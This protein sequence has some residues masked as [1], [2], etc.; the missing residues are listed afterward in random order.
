MPH[1]PRP[2]CD[3]AKAPLWLA[4][5]VGTA[6]LSLTSVAP[7]LAADA[8]PG[9]EHEKTPASQ[10]AQ[11]P[12]LP[13]LVLPKSYVDE[14]APGKSFTLVPAKDGSD[15]L[16][17]ETPAFTARVSPNG[18][19]RFEDHAPKLS[20]RPPLPE[21]VRPGTPTIESALRGRLKILPATP[22]RPFENRPEYK[23]PDSVIP[24]PSPY[25]PDVREECQ[26]P[27]PGWV[28]WARVS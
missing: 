8:A 9:D 16:V 19:V 4:G 1:A 6:T 18:D 14:S 28:A 25:R 17:A 23:P 10:G 7:S 15:D 20:L 11:R 22:P 5:F 26:H 27:R 2:A 3:P 13:L 24:T 12:P 21:P